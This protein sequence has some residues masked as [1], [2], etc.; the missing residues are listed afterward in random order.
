[1]SDYY[2][3]YESKCKVLLFY[4]GDEYEVEDENREVCNY[5]M[6]LKHAVE[7]TVFM[8]FSHGYIMHILSVTHNFI[9]TLPTVLKESIALH[10]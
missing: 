4:C 9:H 5:L 8:L 6:T 10:L 7:S 3:I 1:M 2:W